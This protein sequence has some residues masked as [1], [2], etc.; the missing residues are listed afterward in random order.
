MK[1]QF[2]NIIIV[3]GAA[4]FTLALLLTT[5]LS[6]FAVAKEPLLIIR[7][8]GKIFEEAKDGIQSELSGHFII[9]DFITTDA[10]TTDDISEI[11]S[12]AKPKIVVLM[13][14]NSIR[15]YKEYMAALPPSEPR[16]PSLSMMGVLID[17][18]IQGMDASVGISYEVPIVTS[19]VNLR[20]ALKINIRNIA[21]VH[22]E[23]MSEFIERNEAFCKREG[24]GIIS[25]PINDRARNF[26]SEL[27]KALRAISQE[28]A[29]DVIWIPNDNAL[30]NASTITNVWIPF[31]RKSKT[32]VIVG[33][34]ALVNP[35]LN[36]GT[37][38][39][40]PDNISLGAQAAEFILEIMD[41]DW[42]VDAGFTQPPISV[43]Q[44]INYRQSKELFNVEK[45]SLGEIDQILE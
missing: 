15:M 2:T 30:V 3:K 28:E 42:D 24:I 6:G 17:K 8:D 19:A 44:A 37:F 39:V 43:Y 34:S 13:D 12:V 1:K 4:K 33:V 27:K 23:F 40:L 31:Q 14:N 21:V 22:R 45:S 29:I 9:T 26:E 25:Y 18:A 16:I 36:F 35:D 5:L 38:A 20:A 7:R 11:M 10:V 41:N 32:A